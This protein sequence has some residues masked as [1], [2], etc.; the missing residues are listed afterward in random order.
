MKKLNNIFLSRP[1]NRSSRYPKMSES[2][3]STTWRNTLTIILKE[4]SLPRTLH[5]FCLQAVDILNQI[6]ELIKLDPKFRFEA[7][8]YGR[9][10]REYRETRDTVKRKGIVEALSIETQNSI[11]YIKFILVKHTTTYIK[12]KRLIHSAYYTMYHPRYLAFQ[13]SNLTS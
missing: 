13:P 6:F 9:R 3:H 8:V 10:E 2:S 1:N 12:F 4:F 11:M 5:T 7:A